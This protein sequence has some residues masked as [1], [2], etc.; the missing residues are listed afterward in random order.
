MK[1]RDFE[2]EEGQVSQAYGAGEPQGWVNSESS[3]DV[4]L[5]DAL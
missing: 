5:S 4:E 1:S 3:G 2:M